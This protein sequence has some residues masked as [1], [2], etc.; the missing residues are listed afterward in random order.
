[1]AVAHITKLPIT[2]YLAFEQQ[3][4]VRYEYH[5]G[6]VFAMAG[7]T[8]QHSIICANCAGLLRSEIVAGGKKCI[9]FNS[10]VKVEINEGS[11]YVYPDAA[12]VCGKVNESDTI[13][14]AV[15]NPRVIVEVISASSADYD[16]G[17]KM[18]YYLSLPTVRE[19][20]LIDQDKIHVTLYR[21]YEE[22]NLGSFHYADGLEESITLA[23]LGVSL[24]LSELYRD[25]QIDAPQKES[26]KG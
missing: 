19:I 4:E 12:V 15:R 13:T 9:A 16:R 7:G 17:S 21:R 25:V 1:M 18:R 10:E 11:R 6:E 24:P 23:S 14:G 5:E 3:G 20:L 2:E 26:N 22:S 8:I